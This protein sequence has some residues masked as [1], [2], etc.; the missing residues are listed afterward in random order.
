MG[1]ARTL[2]AGLDADSHCLAR[3]AMAESYLNSP[4]DWHSLM[5]LASPVPAN[6]ASATMSALYD[7]TVD[8]LIVSTCSYQLKAVY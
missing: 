5:T 4:Q 1:L 3:V 7:D 6:V 8:T 2:R